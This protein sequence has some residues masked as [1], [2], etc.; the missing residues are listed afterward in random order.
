MSSH[1]EY[2]QAATSSAATVDQFVRLAAGITPR[3][4]VRVA[5]GVQGALED[6]VRR[7]DVAETATL[8]AC[9]RRLR[10]LLHESAQ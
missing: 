4:R 1:W 2:E 5:F 6:A 8:A 9:L 10:L 3:M 7:S